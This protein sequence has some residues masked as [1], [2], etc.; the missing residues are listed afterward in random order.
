L[1]IVQLKGNGK[2]I[3]GE[4][5]IRTGVTVIMPHEGNIYREKV[6]ASSFILNGYGKTTGL[7][8]VK[9]LGNIESYIGLTNTLNVPLVT[10][11]LIDY[12]IK[13]NPNIWSWF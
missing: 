3:P 1:G 12:H 6:Q 9:E 13:E 11:A 4:G 8:Q 10:D 5:P 2:L 7:V